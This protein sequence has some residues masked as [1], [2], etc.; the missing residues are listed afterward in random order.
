M[1]KPDIKNYFKVPVINDSNHNIAIMKNIV[2]VN[3]EYV[4]S[5]ISLEVRANTG[6]PTRIGNAAIIKSEVMK[7]NEPTVDSKEYSA[8]VKDDHYQKV[9][10]KIDPSELTNEKREQVREM[11]KKAQCSLLTMMT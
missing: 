2:I 1:L 7:A 3:L 4:T 6:D 11:L 9:L 5:T 8:G 10:E